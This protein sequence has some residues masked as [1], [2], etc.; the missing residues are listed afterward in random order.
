[1]SGTDGLDGSTTPVPAAAAQGG[2]PQGS[3]D[4]VFYDAGADNAE[5]KK[6]R[7][8][9]AKLPQTEAGILPDKS[10]ILPSKSKAKSGDAE[11]TPAKKRAA[12]VSSKGQDEKSEKGSN[13]G[14]EDK[15]K[16]KK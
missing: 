2:A 1:M 9:T 12:K 5:K 13:K 16:K 15:Q 14:K 8:T 10:K 11:L 7:A 6:R 4:F 3:A